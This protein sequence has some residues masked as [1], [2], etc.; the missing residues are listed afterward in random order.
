M[1]PIQESWVFGKFFKQKSVFYLRVCKSRS[2]GNNFNHSVGLNSGPVTAGVLRGDRARLQLFGD[3]VNTTARIE[4]TSL[5]NRIH[6]SAI[7]A[8]LIKEAGHRDWVIPRDEIVSAKG[9]GRMNT[10]WLKHGLAKV[11]SARKLNLLQCDQREESEYERNLRRCVDWN[12]ELLL[13]LL[14]KVIAR[15]HAV[16]GRFGPAN[17]ATCEKL[18]C[19]A[20]DLGKGM[21]VV[22]E[23]ANIIELP[24]FDGVVA[25]KDIEI[26]LPPE[27]VSQ[28]HT[29]VARLASMYRTNP[30]HNFEVCMRS[31]CFVK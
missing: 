22:D 11:P 21:L 2:D 13:D 10:Y 30:F 17:R 16:H 28:C 31:S 23:V 19:M 7:T 29:Y 4:T 24:D 8:D 18:K 14:K 6:V 27:V 1:D 20:R 9:K 5:R 3:T 15:R 26:E 12:T 25:S